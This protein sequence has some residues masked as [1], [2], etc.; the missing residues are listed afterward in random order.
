MMPTLGG[1]ERRGMAGIN[2]K[3]NKILGKRSKNLKF[4]S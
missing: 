3:V 1:A 4:I 2:G